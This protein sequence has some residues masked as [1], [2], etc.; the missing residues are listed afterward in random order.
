M[1]VA[2]RIRKKWQALILCLLI[3]LPA[4]GSAEGGYFPD[5][6]IFETESGTAV[7][8]APT[9]EVP[10]VTLRVIV[11]AGSVLDPSGMEGLAGLTAGM[12]MKGAVGLNEDRILER[13]ETVGGRLRVEPGR[14]AVI[15]SGSFLAVDIETGIDLI[16]RILLSPEFD[17]ETLRREK[18]QAISEIGSRRYYSLATDIFLEAVLP[19]GYAHPGQGYRESVERITADDLREFYSD[20][21]RPGRTALVVTGRADRAAVTALAERYFG[22]WKAEGEPERSEIRGGRGFDPETEVLII[23]Q[24]GITQS[25]IR[26]GGSAPSRD[27]GDYYPLTLG[28][29]ILGRGRTSRLYRELR[30]RKGLVYSI[31]SEAGYFRDA[32]Y[33]GVYTYAVNDRVREV[34]DGVLS[35][36]NRFEEG[37]VGEEEI[38]GA[39]KYLTGALPF[40]METSG[41]IA[42]RISDIHLYGLSPDYFDCFA[43]SIKAVSPEK[44]RNSVSEHFLSGRRIIVVLTDY[45]RTRGQF[46]GLGRVEVISR[47]RAESGLR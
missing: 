42:K 1:T 33:F 5:Y 46:S 15:I 21:Y 17:P 31:R 19:G 23:D 22:G 38:A 34:I 35:V 16:S 12:L 3:C 44:V 25:E 45:S 8:I 4:H 28:N 6:E 36:L 39:R 2:V 9:G 7:Y 30:E 32:G 14:D 43:D 13:L 26:I 10:L 11:E 20:Y 41:D 27:T 29:K 47:R 37:A 24:P 40:L 18:R